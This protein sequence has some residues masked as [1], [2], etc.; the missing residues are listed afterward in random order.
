MPALPDP[1]LPSG[2]S[3]TCT[4]PLLTTTLHQPL[5]VRGNVSY[6]F[7]SSTPYFNTSPMASFFLPLPASLP[8]SSHLK[9]QGPGLTQHKE[10]GN[11]AFTHSF[12]HHR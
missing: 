7:L 4:Q 1:C 8:G 11:H 3:S 12:T 2:I 9:G 5:A 6:P 10:P